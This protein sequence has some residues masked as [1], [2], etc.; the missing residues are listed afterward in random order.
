[1]H[2]D[3]EHTESSDCIHLLLSVCLLTQACLYKKGK[4]QVEHDVPNG[5]ICCS[6]DHS[7]LNYMLHLDIKMHEG[8]KLTKMFLTKCIYMF[9]SVSDKPYSPNIFSSPVKL[10]LMSHK[11]KLHIYVIILVRELQS[12]KKPCFACFSKIV[13]DKIPC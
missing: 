1:M 6:L 5:S 8:E 12:D 2:I 7:A 11:F 9:T 10:N 4:V 13:H 3:Y